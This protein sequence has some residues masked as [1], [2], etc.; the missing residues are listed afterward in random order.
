MHL[1]VAAWSEIAAWVLTALSAYGLIWIAGDWRAS[2]LRPVTLEGDHVVVRAGLRWTAHVRLADVRA[3]A[4]P[5]WRRTF[6]SEAGEVNTALFGAPSVVLELDDEVP[7]VGPFG[8]RRRA[9]RIGVALDDPDSFRDAVAA[10]DP[11][12]SHPARERRG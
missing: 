6:G 5:D 2:R 7:V 11:G 12:A 10:A 8:V 1:V 3:A 4:A 9:R